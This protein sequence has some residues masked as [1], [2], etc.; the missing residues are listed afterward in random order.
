MQY[1]YGV[2][3]IVICWIFMVICAKIID[4]SNSKKEW[5]LELKRRIESEQ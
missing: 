2:V 1:L 4:K 3:L 5:Y